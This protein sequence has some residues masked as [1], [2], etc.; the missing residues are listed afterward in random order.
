MNKQTESL[1]TKVAKRS[2]KH[3]ARSWAAEQEHLRLTR[4]ALDVAER[5]KRLEDNMREEQV[6]KAV[7]QLL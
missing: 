4:Q 5:V 7:R 2:P 1:Q 3:P 6:D